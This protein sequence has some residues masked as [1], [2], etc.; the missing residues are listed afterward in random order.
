M[1]VVACGVALNE[2]LEAYEK[3]FK[4]GINI[5]VVDAYSIKPID[6]ITIKRSAYETNGN[7]IVVEDHYFEGGL[8]DAVLNVFADKKD[9]KVI[10][11]AVF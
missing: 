7:M 6:Q 1:T 8:G 11:L 5:R 2:A 9:I 4:A 10:K 3:L